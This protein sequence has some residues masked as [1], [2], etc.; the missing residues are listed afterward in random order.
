MYRVLVGEPSVGN[1]S[2]IFEILR[3]G[4]CEVIKPEAGKP[5]LN[6]ADLLEMI[7]GVDAII[8]GGDEITARVIGVADRLKVIA[9][10]GVGVDSID[11]EAA[12]EKGIV[13]ALAP[14]SIA[15]A[16][17]TLGLMI[18][19]AR[20]I[21]PM[22]ALVRSG[23]W[24]HPAG[25]EVSG[26]TLGL[27]GV[28]RIACAVIQRAKGFDMRILG[29]DVYQDQKLAKELGYEY[30][31]LDQVLREADFLSLHAVL[32][33]ETRGL[34]DRK[35]LSL[36]KPTA[37]IVNTARA[38]IFDEEALYEALKEKRIAGYATDVYS[39]VPPPRDFPLFEVENAI[40]TPWIGAET[41]ETLKDIE[42][43]CAESIL[44]VL[45]GEEAPYPLRVSG[46]P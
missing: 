13:I 9:K 21:V 15:V 46:R 5:H 37:Y 7:K 28:G 4:G 42:L 34:I 43:T 20:R 8:T 17:L 40:T 23:G 29:Y 3:G 18:C 2:D 35:K 11:V 25:V 41:E 12:T 32:S 22:N 30:V 24:E 6:E 16:D 38:Q 1:Y 26:K 10:H 44:R 19:L 36:I 27:I 33:E 45:R 14:C 39:Q 31:S